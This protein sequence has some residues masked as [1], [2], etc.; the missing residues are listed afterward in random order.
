MFEDRLI[1]LMVQNSSTALYAL[2][3]NGRMPYRSPGVLV[4]A[5]SLRV[6]Y[7]NQAA[8]DLIERIHQTQEVDRPKGPLPDDVATLCHKLLAILRDHC[9]SRNSERF[10]LSRVS[11]TRNPPLLLCG[12]GITDQ[13]G[14]EY[15]RICIFMD[16]VTTPF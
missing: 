4:V 5:T 12:I 9:Q 3:A 16:Q 11:G 6:L 10:Q 15:S 8:R 2:P 7:M 13:N 1:H 14:L